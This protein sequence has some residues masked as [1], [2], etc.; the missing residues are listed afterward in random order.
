MANIRLRSPYYEYHTQSGA[1]SAKLELTIE[2]T[3]RYTIIKD[4]PTNAVT[5]EIAELARDY[6][7]ITYSGSYLSQKVSISGEITWYDAAN[8]GGSVTGTS[9][10]FTHDGFDGYWDYYNAEYTN[11][12][13]CGTSGYSCIMQD[14]TIIYVPENQGGFVPVLASGGIVY[15][16]FTG[17]TTS[18]AVGQPSTTVTIKRIPCSKYTAMKVTFVNKYGALQDI[19]FDK[20]SVETLTTSIEQYKNNNLSTT[21]TYSRYNHQYKTLQKSGQET[22][23]LNTGYIDE[24]MNE[25]IKQLMLSEQVWMHMGA[26]IHPV[27]VVTNSLTFKK[28]VNDKLINYTLDFEHAHDHIDRVR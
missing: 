28:S 9:V 8:A 3:L 4:T 21:G 27:N 19:Y 6:L 2:G 5:F 7:D 18:I 26:E 24:G 25:V 15:E 12:Q 14:N 10:T 16:S 17:S 1:Q 23:T 20:K 22:M 13:F 11:K